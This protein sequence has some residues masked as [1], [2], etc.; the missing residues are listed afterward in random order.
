MAHA[1]TAENLFQD[2]QQLPA[3]E[4]QKFFS[5]LSARA[6]RSD[7]L[8][9][10][11]LFG[12]LADDMFTAAEAAEYLEVSMSTFRRHVAGGK[13]DASAKSIAASVKEKAL[14]YQI[15]PD[16][17]VNQQMRKAFDTRDYRVER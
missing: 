17:I 16:T 12:H 8:S 6:F 1:T 10:E 7:D 11:Q 13:L 9:H 3:S 15:K 2:L 5:I 4:L 14:Q